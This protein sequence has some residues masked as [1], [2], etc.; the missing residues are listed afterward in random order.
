VPGRCSRSVSA[1]AWP[2]STS[3]SYKLVADG[4]VFSG[5]CPALDAQTIAALAREHSQPAPGQGRVNPAR[6]AH[7]RARQPGPATDIPRR[8]AGMQ[9][10]DALCRGAAGVQ[11]RRALPAGVV[12]LGGGRS[13][14]ARGA[15]QPPARACAVY[16][17]QERLTQVGVPKRSCSRLAA[18]PAWTA[19]ARVGAGVSSA[20]S[21]SRGTPPKATRLTTK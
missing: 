16:V 9:L 8:Y 10:P 4:T 7:R 11:L 20:Q 19:P 15:A 12:A 2:L 3:G 18:S 17:V 21:L 5:P 6:G 1:L 14:R 13:G